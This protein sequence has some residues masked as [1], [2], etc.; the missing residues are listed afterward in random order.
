MKWGDIDLGAGTVAIRRKGCS[1]SARS[2]LDVVDT[3][4]GVSETPSENAPRESPA[5]DDVVVRGG[6]MKVSGLERSAEAYHA[7][8]GDG[9]GLSVWSWPGLNAEAIANRVGEEH[10]DLNALPQGKI[11]AARVSDL[12]A[13]GWD[14][15]RSGPRDG[16]VTVWRSGKP[17]G[18]DW[19]ELD[20][21]FGL[22]Q[23]NPIARSRGG[24]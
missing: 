24:A 9:Y 18:E 1:L 6:E 10:P 23:P 3:G 19:R 11:R 5:P 20:R 22:P 21:C 13:G 8:F 4:E 17:S 2:C 15:F 12:V 7:R 16:H 14:L